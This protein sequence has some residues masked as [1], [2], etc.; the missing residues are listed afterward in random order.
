MRY[1]FLFFFF[2][3]FSGIIPGQSLILFSDPANKIDIGKQ[4]L[5]LKDTSNRLSI[6]QIITKKFTWRASN[7]KILN[8]NADAFSYWIKFRVKNLSQSDNLV[9]EL[10]YPI[11][12]HVELYKLSDNSKFLLGKMGEDK[13]FS[14]RKYNHQ[15]YIFDLHLVKNEQG[16]FFLK[17]KAGEQKIVP[18]SIGTLQNIFEANIIRDMLSGMYYGIIIVMVLYNLFIFFTIRDRIYLYYVFY[19]LLIGLTQASL[20]GHAFKYLWSE[21][22][23]IANVSIYLTSS[24]VGISAVTFLRRALNIRVFFPLTNM[25]LTIMQVSY[26]I[27][28][29]LSLIGVYFSSYS[30]LNIS[31]DLINANTGLISLLLLYTSYKIYR[32][33]Y[34]PAKFILFGWSV[35]L[36]CAILYVLKLYL[37]FFPHNTFTSMIL[38][39]GSSIE[40]I[41]FS[42]ALA[43]RIN[44]IKEEKEK[45]KMEMNRKIITS[46]LK[47]LRA[48]MDPHFTFNSM[49]AIQH[50]IIKNDKESAQHYLVRF[51]QLIRRILDNSKSSYISVVDELDTLK[52]YLELESLRF[53]NS[54]TYEII[55]DETISKANDCIPSML[56][57]PYLE[58]A[59]WHGL[60]PKQGSGKIEL[61][62]S[63]TENIITCSIEDNGIGREKAMKYS[64]SKHGHKSM[65]MQITR[66]RLEILNFVHHAKL[67]VKITDLKNEK[68]E[69]AGTKVEIHIPLV[70]HFE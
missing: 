26:A 66:E 3:F 52:L 7:Q 35:F 59:I 43:D 58:N 27:P 20:K 18:L 36:T 55:V 47:A 4:V 50:F 10:S 49:N 60:M 29:T 61:K 21:Y 38:E 54:F 63:K 37:P 42:F 33:R 39:F 2:L 41:L 23:E 70:N 45:E 48:Q 19:I 62:L 11:L 31:S 15:N 5:I 14:K 57:Q 51:A 24:L 17:V 56:I 28:I 1:I 22:P 46:E 40:V 8:L 69:A 13:P 32:A 68:E 16:T 64:K 25:V 6:D 12:D 67:N 53:G 44:I 30:S 9:L 65:G 34:R